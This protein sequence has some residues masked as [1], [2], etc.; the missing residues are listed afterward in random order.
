MRIFDESEVYGVFKRCLREEY[1]DDLAT[2]LADISAYTEK[3][4]GDEE[5]C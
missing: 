2:L 5:L 3:L 1:G 4:L